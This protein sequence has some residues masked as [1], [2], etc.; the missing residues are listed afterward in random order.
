MSFKASSQARKRDGKLKD[1][2]YKDDTEIVKEAELGLK[3]HLE[4]LP[5]LDEDGNVV[6]WS[7]TAL[8]YLRKNYKLK[9][10]Y[11]PYIAFVMGPQ[12]TRGD[13]DSLQIW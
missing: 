5:K 12:T 13:H 2:D 10:R 9:E 6:S 4:M 11:Q 1:F 3:E 8:K 7:P